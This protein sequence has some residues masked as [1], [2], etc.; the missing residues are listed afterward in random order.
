MVQPFFGLNV[1]DMHRPLPS[2][3]YTAARTTGRVRRH[4]HRLPSQQPTESWPEEVVHPNRAAKPPPLGT[5]PED[6]P[7]QSEY[8]SANEGWP[9]DPFWPSSG[10]PLSALVRRLQTE[11]VDT[12]H[13]ALSPIVEGD[14]L[15]ESPLPGSRAVGAGVPAAPGSSRYFLAPATTAPV[16]ALPPGA[17]DRATTN[18]VDVSS[19]GGGRSSGAAGAGAGSGSSA[20][21]SANASASTTAGSGGGRGRTGSVGSHERGRGR[22]RGRDGAFGAESGRNSPVMM[23]AAA[24]ARRRQRGK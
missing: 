4:A 1:A 5:V 2:Y 13:T 9:D 20:V 10:R 11:D 21:A 12:L 16:I 14:E 22:G 3:V 24:S 23:A 7:V 15:P 6:G 8:T 18:G 17:V 19:A